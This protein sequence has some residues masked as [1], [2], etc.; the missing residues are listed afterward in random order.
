MKS[1]IRRPAS[2][3]D[4]YCSGTQKAGKKLKL[5]DIYVVKGLKGLM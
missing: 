5:Y 4:M 1:L 3:L 2:Q